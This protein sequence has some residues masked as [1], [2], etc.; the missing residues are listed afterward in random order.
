MGEKEIRDSRA[1]VY[2]H[3]NKVKQKKHFIVL[4]GITKFYL[5]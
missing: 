4:K 1:G 5:R 2:S 3:E